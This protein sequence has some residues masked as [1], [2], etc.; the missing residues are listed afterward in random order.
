[1]NDKVAFYFGCWRRQRAGHF[2]HE[3]NGC[4]VYYPRE[5]IKDLPWDESHM[6]TGLLK[7]GKHPDV[8]DGK[9]WWTCGGKDASW[10]AFCWWDSSGDGRGGSN[11]GFYVRGFGIGEHEAA[12]QFACEIFPQIVERQA[13]PL[14]LQ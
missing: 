1:M 7:N 4:T 9:V 10:H 11:S 3:A 14:K 6:D 5:V 12:F 13:V 8:V 2:L